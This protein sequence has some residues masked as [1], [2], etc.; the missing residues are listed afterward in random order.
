MRNSKIILGVA[1]ETGKIPIV[2][3]I[4][5]FE[6][7]QKCWKKFWMV[8]GWLINWTRSYFIKWGQLNPA[9]WLKAGRNT[10]YDTIVKKGKISHKHKLTFWR[11]MEGNRKRMAGKISKAVSSQKKEIAD[12]LKKNKKFNKGI[13]VFLSKNLFFNTEAKYK[14]NMMKKFVIGLA[15]RKSIAS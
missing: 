11:K 3:N 2:F 13:W 9:K 10:K 5:F 14:Q 15:G 8:T 4:K 1:F 12:K 6:L 7:T